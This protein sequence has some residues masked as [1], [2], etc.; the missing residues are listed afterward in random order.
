MCLAI[1]VETAFVGCSFSHVKMIKMRLR[2]H[3]GEVKPCSQALRNRAEERES[4]VTTEYFWWSCVNLIHYGY[5]GNLC[6]IHTH[7]VL[8]ETGT[9]PESC[10]QPYKNISPREQRKYSQLLLFLQNKVGF[11]E[12]RQSVSERF[13]TNNK[14]KQKT[15]L[16]LSLASSSHFGRDVIE[17]CCNG[18]IRAS[19][20]AHNSLGFGLAGSMQ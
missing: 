3:L 11:S 13:C 10:W 7:N 6:I 4:L 20:G 1:P 9:L 16:Q 5:D 18:E 14:R 8:Q 12:L 17:A 2:N 19:P 15:L